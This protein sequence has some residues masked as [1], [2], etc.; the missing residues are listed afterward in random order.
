MSF[1]LDKN[2]IFEK[3]NFKKVK[4]IKKVT[5]EAGIYFFRLNKGSTFNS[6]ENI[7]ND[8]MIYI[9]KSRK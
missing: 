6:F 1:S 7:E 2:S 8:R 3:L 4:H 5:E 9:G